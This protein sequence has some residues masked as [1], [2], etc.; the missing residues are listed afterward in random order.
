MGNTVV[1][2][3]SQWG[4]EGKGKI[5]NYLSERADVVVRYQGGDN[6]GHTICFGG[7]TYKL[8]L[9]PSG[10]FN[11]NIKNV[12]GNGVVLNPKNFK[13]ELEGLKALG[14]E[15]NNLYISERAQVIFDYHLVLDGLNENKLGPNKIGTTKKG[16][17]PAYTDKVSRQGFR[18][19]DLVASDFKEKYKLALE[20]KNNEIVALGGEKIDYEKSLK[21]YM[22]LADYIKPYIS[23]TISLLDEEYKQGKKILF[24]GAQGALLDIDFGT[25]P[26][27]TSSN[28]TT[29]GASTGTGL[30]PNKIKEVIGIVKAYT[31]RVGAGAF[32]TE[33]DNE[34]GSIIR[35]KAHEYGTTTKRPRRVGW[36]DAVVLK[37][38]A[39][40]NGLTGISLMLLDILS[41]LDEIKICTSYN[42]NGK[43]IKTVPARNDDF[44]M[45]EPNYITMPGWHED[46]TKCT[47]FEEL[48]ENAKKYI[49]K[50][51]ELTGVDVVFVSVGAGREQTIIRKEIF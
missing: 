29:G 32:P 49:E 11:P 1:V 21:E 42:L 8:H 51:E 12:I 15:C 4:D 23:D 48:P 10:I 37:Y 16:I 50:I 44:S 36:L 33:Q 47:T 7:E 5:T 13:T 46:I 9:I 14:F 6:A 3:G 24:E 31:T 41:E 19:A 35:E 25:Y 30:A 22:E 20:A 38:S 26:F 40:I 17:G 28:P 39:T 43:V 27:V 34:I 45:C 18:I 2:I